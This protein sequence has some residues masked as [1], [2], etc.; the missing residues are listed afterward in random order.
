MHG[1]AA[2]GESLIA[3]PCGQFGRARFG[4]SGLRY[5]WPCSTLLVTNS[6]DSTP[7]FQ[8]ARAA[9][10]SRPP[11]VVYAA[12]VVTWV[13]ATG[14]ALLIMFLAL[15][16]LWLAA[17]VFGAFDSGPENPGWFVVEAVGVVVALSAA[18]DLVALFLLRGHRWARWVLIGLC[19][20][21]AA[22]GVMLAYYIVPLLV[23]A[24][25]VAVTALLLLPGAG[26]WFRASRVQDQV[27]TY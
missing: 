19:V 13:G 24:A 12:A 26:A 21:A 2:E 22:G 27:A 11:G 15:S 5:W 16:L 18:A 17:P 3:L 6:A 20:V 25:A 1:S 23:T 10:P 9:G 8:P 4:D 7:G 14:T